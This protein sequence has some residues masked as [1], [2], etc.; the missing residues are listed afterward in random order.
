MPTPWKKKY[1]WNHFPWQFDFIIFVLSS[2]V[3]KRKGTGGQ[4]SIHWISSHLHKYNRRRERMRTFQRIFGRN[5]HPLF[6]IT[7]SVILGIR[8]CVS[9]QTSRLIGQINPKN[10]HHH[11]HRHR[12]GLHLHQQQNNHPRH[13]PGSGWPPWWIIEYVGKGYPR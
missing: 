1:F 8:L 7:F 13:Y 2:D 6:L 9:Q 10:C 4:F 11:Q 12:K 5:A 3:E